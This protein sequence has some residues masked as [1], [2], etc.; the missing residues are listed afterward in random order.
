MYN[1]STSPKANKQWYT[2]IKNT[3]IDLAVNSFNHFNLQKTL[4][5]PWIDSYDTSEIEQF[6]SNESRAN[7]A[8]DSDHQ[9]VY[10]IWDM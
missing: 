4:V 9:A 8:A 7:W 10:Q 6:P 3:F 2:Y 1:N 5:Y